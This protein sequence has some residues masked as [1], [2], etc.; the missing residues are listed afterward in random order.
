VNKRQEYALLHPLTDPYRDSTAPFTA[1][2]THAR[3]FLLC[4]ILAVDR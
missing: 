2:R 1:V 4:S 3:G